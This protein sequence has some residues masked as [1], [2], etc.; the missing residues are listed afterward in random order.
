[1]RSLV[2][3]VVVAGCGEV[4]NNP[5]DGGGGSDTG[6]GS[7]TGVPFDVVHVGAADERVG[8]QDVQIG[9]NTVIDTDA[10]TIGGMTGDFVFAPQE[11]GGPDLAV[12]HAKA[13]MIPSGGVALVKGARELVII[14]D[15][16][17]INGTLDAGGKRT[18]PGPGARG[19]GQPGTGGPGPGCVRL[20]PASSV[21]LMTIVSAIDRKSVV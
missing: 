19:M 18:Q 13:F 6:S 9:A 1:V 2:L 20:P 11:G 14:A 4:K 16:I 17:V 12:L 7:D 10:L 15:T 8:M 3:V 21:P 5:G